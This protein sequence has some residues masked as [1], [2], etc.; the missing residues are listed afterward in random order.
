MNLL[1]GSTEVV[2]ISLNTFPGSRFLITILTGL[3]TLGN[4]SDSE[5]VRFIDFASAVVS[6]SPYIDANPCEYTTFPLAASTTSKKYL[7]R[8]SVSIGLAGFP[9]HA[10]GSTTTRSTLKCSWVAL[11]VW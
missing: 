5:N 10:S 2:Q 8:S 6:H 11:P 3:S 9:G 1:A 7:P 4:R